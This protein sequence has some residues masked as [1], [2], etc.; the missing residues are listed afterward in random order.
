MKTNHIRLMIA[1]LGC[2][3]LSCEKAFLEKKPDNALLVPVNLKDFQALLDNSNTVMNYAPFLSVYSTDDFYMTDNGFTSAPLDVQNS[4]IWAA[5]I[6]PPTATVTDWNRMYT[7]VFYAN[8]VLDGLQ[9]IKPEASLQTE[10]DQI[11]GSALFYR[12]FA[13]YQ[14]AQQFALPYRVA[15]AGG[16]LGIPIRLIGDVNKVSERGTLQ[17]TY[18]QIIRDLK[19][20]LELLPAK[21]VFKTRPGKTAVLA[22]L[23]RVYQ[24][25]E[26]H[27]RAGTYAAACLQLNN[28]LTDYN[29]L[30]VANARP[31]PP[32]LPDGN[33]EVLFYCIMVNSGLTSA[34]SGADPELY[35]SYS[36]N[37]LRKA[38]FFTDKG[39]GL[40]NFKGSYTGTANIFAGLAIDEVY[41]IRAESYARAGQT[42]EAMQD[43]N[44]LLQ[45]RWKRGTFVPLT[46]LNPEDALKMVLTERRK[47]LV[48]RNM[49]WTDL[50]RLNQDARFAVKLQRQVKGNNYQLLPNDLRY[51]FPIPAN[52]IAAGSIEQNPR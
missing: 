32:A 49:R 12:A 2:M 7:Q 37:D 41:L 5:E 48:Y 51:V 10:Y 25:M 16:D 29:T 33:D 14:L 20:A 1:V 28:S 17:K 15:T 26:D 23:A 21:G 3:C 47:E 27:G 38:A 22:M 31:F 45:K 46:A 6:F 50:R 52:V 43:L 9:D 40:I 11:K 34:L 8:V 30:T 19:E 13:F 44:T 35:R 39:N 4:Y 18:S 42:A 36:S 24:T